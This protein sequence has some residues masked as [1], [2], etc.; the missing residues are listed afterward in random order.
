MDLQGLEK[1]IH[2]A[3]VTSHDTIVH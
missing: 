3:T 1:P 2:A